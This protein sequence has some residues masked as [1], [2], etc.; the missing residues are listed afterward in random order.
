MSFWVE[1][2]RSA[3]IFGKEKAAS[4]FGGSIR[5][6]AQKVSTKAENGKSNKKFCTDGVSLCNT[7]LDLQ[8]FCSKA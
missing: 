3:R 6:L 4:K 8:P 7:L 5:F 2:Q 1:N